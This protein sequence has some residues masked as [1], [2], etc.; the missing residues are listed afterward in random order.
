MYALYGPKHT[1]FSKRKAIVKC[2]VFKITQT[3][4][5]NQ[6]K[7]IPLSFVFQN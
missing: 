7:L 4:P 2:T 3:L 5:M 1:E 6:L